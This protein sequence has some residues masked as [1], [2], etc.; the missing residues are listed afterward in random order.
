MVKLKNYHYIC[1]RIIR[2]NLMGYSKNFELS[3]IQNIEFRINLL[4]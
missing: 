3:F 4:K 2:E 1:L